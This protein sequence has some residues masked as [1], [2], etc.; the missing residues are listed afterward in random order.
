M[1][2]TIKLPDEQEA[3]LNAKAQAQGVSA[4]EY[5]R[6]VLVHDL[7]VSARPPRRHISEIIRENMSRVPA[8]IMATLPKDGASEHDHYIYGLPKRNL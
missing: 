7:E 6:Q 8:E 3:A 2:L 1:S 5:A 4:E